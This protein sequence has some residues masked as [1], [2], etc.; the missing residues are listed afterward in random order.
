MSFAVKLMRLF[1]HFYVVAV[2]A[3]ADAPCQKVNLGFGEFHSNQA[4]I[5]VCRESAMKGIDVGNL[6]ADVY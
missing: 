5:V 1:F 6:V 2:F 4:T 3:P